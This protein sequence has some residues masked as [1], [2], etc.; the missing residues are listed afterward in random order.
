MSISLISI[1]KPQNDGY[2]P[3]FEDIDGYGGYQVQPNTTTRDAIHTLNRKVG[4][5]VYVV[6]TDSFY[7]LDSDLTTW[8]IL[9]LGT[10]TL[11]G[12]LIGTLPNPTVRYLTG[13]DG[14]VLIT[15]PDL[16]F[17]NVAGSN[18]II[19]MNSVNSTSL[20]SH[21]LINGAENTGS[22]SAVGGGIT[23]TSGTGPNAG[24]INLIGADADGGDAGSVILSGGYSTGNGGSVGIAAGDGLTTITSAGGSISL[25][26]GNSAGDL[27]KGGEFGVT[28]GNGGGGGGSIQITTGNGTVPG[29]GDGGD[30]LVTLGTGD[31]GG[32]FTFNAGNGDNNGGSFVLSAGSAL[33]GGLISIGAGDSLATTGAG[34]AISITGGDAF[35]D[36]G[37]GG[38][39]TIK[40]GDTPS[41]STTTNM[42]DIT[43]GYDNNCALLVRARNSTGTRFGM[44]DATRLG[45]QF[46]IQYIS[47]GDSTSISIFRNTYIVVDNRNAGGG[48][49]LFFPNDPY[50][51]NGHQIVI[52]N[53]GFGGSATTTTLNGNTN[54]IDDPATGT[55]AAT[56][57]ISTIGTF[58]FVYSA[59][60]W[61]YF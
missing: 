35:D 30:M 12:D 37:A 51:Q 19:Q 33:N 8:N 22:G 17:V 3:V 45:I 36:Y 47:N 21:L 49:T 6:A 24:S 46:K 20:T 32:S 34:G 42:P 1:I 11:G 13:A 27:K 31:D 44:L 2:F 7:Q 5:L 26:T 10:V 50:I 15:S 52:R 16:Q 59:G 4:M 25:G 58:S 48:Q 28:T 23:I 18:H 53:K 29:N 60:V 41:V 54:T 57:T 43:L 40:P 39:I 14:Y 61:I 56:V 38:A 55:P 9:P